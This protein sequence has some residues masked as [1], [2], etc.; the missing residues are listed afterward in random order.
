MILWWLATLFVTVQL[1]VLVTNT[2]TFPVLVSARS[3]RTRRRVSLLIPARNEAL[4][5]P[6]T[7][8]LL[9]TQGADEVIVLDDGSTDATPEI[10]AGFRGLRCV[11]GKPLPEGWVGKNWACHQLAG[12]A[13]GD[14]LVFTDADVY[15]EPGALTALLT[16]AERSDA[17]VYWEPGALTALLTFAERSD[18]VYAS[19]WPRQRTET[20]FERLAVPVIDT[21]LLG[22]LPYPLVKN[23][24]DALF[25]AGNGQCMMWTRSA[26]S[27]VGGHAA[28]RGEVLEDVRMG[29][30]A[31]GRGL[32]LVLAL[33]GDLLSTRMYRTQGELLE[34]FSK[35]ILAAHGGRL[36]L[37]FSVLLSTLTYTLSWVLAFA[38]PLWLVPAALGMFQRALTA[39]KTHRSPLEG[40]L[41]PFTAYPLLRVVVRALSRKGY[42]W[43]GRSYGAHD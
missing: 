2:F 37:L 41:Q 21:I 36:P 8:P 32:K 27:Q 29:Q 3:P 39:Y 16:F 5:L 25:S 17:D 19:V 35:N 40:F 34:G 38:N 9:L 1:V 28:F 13:T 12:V 30:A 33:G 42:R 43:K 31:K 15:W 23:T 24:T 26:Y 7:V 10:L 20:L 14:V 4:N 6:E 18:A 11:Q 22:L